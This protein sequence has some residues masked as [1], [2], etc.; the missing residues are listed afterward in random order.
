MSETFDG[1]IFVRRMGSKSVCSV[2][3]AEEAVQL[4]EITSFSDANACF[5]EVPEVPSRRCP[6]GPHYAEWSERPRHDPPA[7][8]REA[9]PE[10]ATETPKRKRWWQL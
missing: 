8:T 2:C 7:R 4:V 5:I 3:G 10:I 6:N 9:V 1:R